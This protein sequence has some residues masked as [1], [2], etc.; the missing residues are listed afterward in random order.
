MENS[1]IMEIKVIIDRSKIS[2][3]DAPGGH[4]KI[5]PFTGFVESPLFTGEILPGGADVQV[6]NAAGVRHMCAQYM[7]AGKD[8]Q[9]NPCHLFVCNNAY[10]ERDHRPKPFEACPT[11][12][13]DSPVLGPYLHGAHFRAEGHSSPEGVN[14]RVFDI[15]K[16]K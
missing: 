9:G 16:E 11:F 14:I 15:D 12:L 6:T 5:I 1:M 4:A 8:S 7:F 3:L 2:E 10:F 13:T